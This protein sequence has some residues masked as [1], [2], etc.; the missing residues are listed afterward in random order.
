MSYP[1]LT[2]RISSSTLV[3][4]RDRTRQV[5]NIFE[6]GKLE[7][8]RFITA[9]S[10]IARNAVQFAGEGTIVFSFRD[11]K[12]DSA[13]ALIALISDNGKGIADIEGVLA[14]RVINNGQ[15]PLGIVGA[16]RLVDV[17]HIESTTNG[18]T[19]TIEMLLPRSAARFTLI[20]LGKRVEQLARQKPKTP[21]QELEKQNRDMMDTL[22]ELR[23]KQLELQ[24]ADERK[25]QF[26]TTLAHELR[27]PLGTL[28]MNLEILRRNLE[29]RPDELA[30]RREIMARQ[31][32]R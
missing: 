12:D 25:N 26:L 10:E 8:T 19:V 15:I 16:K 22:Q 31:T 14:G 1:I 21:V 20:E 7:S 11:G 9:V 17:L 24:R 2:T 28:H 29:L 4:L 13:S 6:L 3:T 18:T 32:T 5:A 23:E 27:T 30:K